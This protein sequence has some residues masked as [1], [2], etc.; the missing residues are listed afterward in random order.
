M[1]VL[2]ETVVTF[3]L[4]LGAFV[5]AGFLSGKEIVVY[6]SGGINYIFVGAITFFVVLLLFFLGVKNIKDNKFFSLLQKIGNFIFLVGM[7]SGMN[8]LEKIIFNKNFYLFS[9]L[10]LL[11]ANLISSKGMDGIKKLSLIL[12]PISILIVNCV[13]IISK[14]GEN[15]STF[16]VQKGGALTS[17]LYVFINVFPL[18]P[19]LK[20]TA[21]KKKLKTFIAPI[22]LFCVFFFVQAFFILKKV[23][24][25]G[26]K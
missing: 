10:S 1:K 14:N 3:F 21:R 9:A 11:L 24:N 4:T 13:L 6:F 7:V 5:G 15:L 20:K 16:N 26:T 17:V 18:I 19:F 23:I 25:I 8:A 12:M 2:C 22:I